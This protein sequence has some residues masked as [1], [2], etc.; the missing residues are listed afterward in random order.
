MLRAI[1]KKSR[2]RERARLPDPRSINLY[3]D[4][5]GSGHALSNSS[6]NAID[7]AL[8]TQQQMLCQIDSTAIHSDCEPLETAVPCWMYTCS[9][10]FSAVLGDPRIRYPENFSQIFNYSI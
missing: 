3:Y 1:K 9:R 10:T 2:R 6:N 5:C 8:F 4:R 7:S